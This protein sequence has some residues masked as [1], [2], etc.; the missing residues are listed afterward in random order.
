MRTFNNLYKS[1]VKKAS[2]ILNAD[3][4]LF[5]E[6]LLKDMDYDVTDQGKAYVKKHFLGS[7]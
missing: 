5:A 4:D 6:S 2:E 1:Y 3:S 7:A